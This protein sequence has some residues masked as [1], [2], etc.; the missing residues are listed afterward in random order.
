MYAR[1]YLESEKLVFLEWVEDMSSSGN[2]NILTKFNAVNL[3]TIFLDQ[4]FYVS[5]GKVR[6]ER[7]IL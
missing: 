4:K 1:N 3:L 2:F 5:L 7:L 6:G